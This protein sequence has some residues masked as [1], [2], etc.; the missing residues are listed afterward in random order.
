MYKCERTV[1]ISCW[2]FV[3]TFSDYWYFQEFGAVFVIFKLNVQYV[4]VHCYTYSF[5]KPDKIS[6]A[7]TLFYTHSF[8]AIVCQWCSATSYY[9]AGFAVEHP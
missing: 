8:T 4:T 7:V 3:R 1:F 2:L 5:M 6:P 9:I